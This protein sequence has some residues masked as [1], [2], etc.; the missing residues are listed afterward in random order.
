MLTDDSLDFARQHISAFYDTDFY[1]KPFEYGAL[2][3]FWDDVKEHLLKTKENELFSGLPRSIAWPKARGGYR[4]VHQLEPLDAIVYIALT[5]SVANQISDARM[6]PSV[7]TSYCIA[8][9]HSSFFSGGSGFDRY[10]KR[11]EQLSA[12]FKYVLST[13]ISDFYN[14]V[15][16]HR[17]G[18]A[19][20]SATGDKKAGFQ[21]EQFIT[22]LNNKASQGLPIGPSPS[23]VLAE[24][25]MIDV[26]QFIHGQDLDH[27]R[28][29][30]DIPIFGN[31]KRKLEDCL[32]RK[33]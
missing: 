9:D 5:Y 15:Y 11:C 26:D 30:D 33:R 24:A 3:Y 20:E 13:D 29:V 25:V 10:R 4:V 2:W 1:P 31:S 14:Q 19:I 28:Y 21:I 8:L 22:R 27:V 7:A 23:V 17:V 12:E 16:L 18:N 6:G 32:E